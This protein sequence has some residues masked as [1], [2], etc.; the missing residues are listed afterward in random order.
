M[1]ISNTAIPK[2]YSRFRDSVLKGDIVVCET[3]S[4]EMNRIDDL[5]KH[6]GVYYD[7]SAVEGWIEFCENELVL[8]DGSPL[9]L[10]DSFKLW[11]EQ[12][13]GWYYFL[14]RSVPVLDGHGGYRYVNK[15]VKKRLV[16]KQYLITARGSAKSLYDECVQAYGLVIDFETTQQIVTA[17]TMKQAD[18]I[19]GPLRTAILKS[20]GPLFQ[21]LTAGS[22]QNTT[23]SRMNRP[24][25]FSSKKGIENTLTNS[26]MEVL[27]MSVDKLQGYRPKYSTIDE[28]LSGDTRED[29]VAALEQ[30]ATKLDDWIILLTS[31]EGTVRNGIGDTIKL[32][33]MKILR[34]EYYNPYV[35]IF[36]YKLDDI[37]EVSNPSMWIKANPNLGKTV[38]MDVYKQDVDRAEQSPSSRNEILAKRFGIPLE[39]Y[40]YFFTFEETKVCG[41]P[42]NFWEMPCALGA[43]LSQGDD[44]CAF[45]FLF[46]LSNGQ[47]G[48]KVR[49]YITQYT[50]DNLHK[51]L[52][53]KYEEFIMEG[54]L[55]VMDGT[56][57]DII[58]VYDDLM[59][60]I[61]NRSYDV[62]A[63]GYDPY[64][65]QAFVTRWEAENGSYGVKKVPQ[66]S[67]TESVPLGEIKK[68]SEKGDILF[69]EKLMSFTMG[70]CVVKEDT[71]GNR[72]LIKKRREEKIDN[73]SAMLDAYVAFKD[74]GEMF[75]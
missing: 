23:G 30:G 51:A 75:E 17:P 49:S 31:S 39:G 46:P 55:I 7:D 65:A 61:A 9:F 57:L 58:E 10:L 6:P 5:I 12:L 34:G 43:D 14:E 36:Y 22:I 18:E 8:T 3:I 68:L 28:W 1:S 64:Y 40:T 45:T 50:L 25:L 38:Q 32:E 52:R 15:M 72:K 69:D 11:G 74:F 48:V 35:S 56:V 53:S 44:F 4:M 70:H 63:F 37:R 21:F 62:R 59:N 19:L 73:V 47:F 20:R 42:L 33:L 27:P 41:R 24:K 66:G 13:F 60:H 2:Y 16:N 26:I 71:N 29:V 67:K 54:T